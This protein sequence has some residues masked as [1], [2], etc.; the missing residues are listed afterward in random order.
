MNLNEKLAGYSLEHKVK[1]LNE[2]VNKQKSVFKGKKKFTYIPDEDLWIALGAEP[3]CKPEPVT[4]EMDIYESEYVHSETERE[5]AR[6]ILRKLYKENSDEELRLKIAMAHG[7]FLQTRHIFKVNMQDYLEKKKK[8]FQDA[9]VK[10]IFKDLGISIKYGFVISG[11]VGGYYLMGYA[12]Y[13]LGSCCY[14]FYK[15]EQSLR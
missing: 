7:G 4:K 11:V 14:E 6:K 3:S 12:L 13:K 15:I 1:I 2:I 5:E 10:T 9:P 8:E